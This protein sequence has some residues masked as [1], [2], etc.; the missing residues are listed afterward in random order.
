M[1]PAARR[2]RRPG[3]TS[4]LVNLGIAVA[5]LAIL[6]PLLL[7]AA[8]SAP[9]TA[10]EFSPNATQ[11]IKTPP[12]GEAAATN[13]QGKGGVGPGGTAT[14][15]PTPTKTEQVSSNLLKQCVGPPPLR[16]IEDPQ[17][18]PCIAYWK[19]DN[20]GAT[21][22]GVTQ[23]A[24]YIAVPTPESKEAQYNALFKFF[25]DRFEFY[26]RKLIP[27]YCN[28][29][30]SGSADQA[31][32]VADAAT[33]ATGCN[34]K[35]P[36]P[37]VSTMYRAGNN[38]S[39]YIPQ[40]ACRYHI[41]ALGSYA[42]FDSKFMDRCAPYVWQ[43]PMLADDEFANLGE[44]AC[45]RLAGRIASYGGTS[46]VKLGGK[47]LDKLPRKFGILL[48]PFTDDD[49]MDR[50]GALDPITSRLKACGAQI[51]SRDAIVNPVSGEFDPAT[52]QN[53]ILQLKND[54]VTSIFCLC[55][56]YSFGTLGRA[57][58]ASAYTPEWISSTIGLNDVDSSFILG[59]DLGTQL[60]HTF[61]IT[62]QP[63]IVPPLENPY[64]IALQ[65]GDPSQAPDTTV[66]VEGE[67]EVYRAL[68][69]I[70][71]GVQMAGPHLTPQSFAAGLEKTRFPNPI[72]STHAGAVGF[73][74]NGYSMTDDGAE[75]WY[76][77]N[78]V[79]PFSDSASHRGTVCYLSGGRRYTLGNWPRGP[80]PFF[81]GRCDS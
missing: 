11:V 60:Q 52:A 31:T 19:G 75:W 13:G 44:W 80:A 49:P 23:D 9:P 6:L 47:P 66:L 72:T 18:P 42:P 7:T 73:H 53:A 8:T 35:K 57:A 40:M 33:S 81:K 68:L 21:S 2:L 22:Q 63:R 51:A 61:G 15:T 39:Y 29:S 55:N 76:D 74:D 5:V 32:Q 12:P 41:I 62:F 70:A 34:G 16:Q 4:G 56:F 77:V 48:E 65:E 58:A 1:S 10:S 50:P 3:R 43:Y 20:G 38:G 36:K 26:G 78:A 64:N 28:G 37:F 79:G 14:P 67:E 27:E 59:A 24:I 46:S 30:Y 17:S 71:S 45:N 54:G 25:N 69:L